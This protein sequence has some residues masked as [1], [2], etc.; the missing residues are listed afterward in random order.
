[1]YT[2]SFFNTKFPSICHSSS[3]NTFI[4]TFFISSTTL[5]TSLS[6]PL[7]IFIF[8]LYLPQVLLLLLLLNYESILLWLVFNFCCSFLL[9]LSS[10]VFSLVYLPFLSLF[11]I[12]ALRWNQ[13][14]TN[15]RSNR[16][17]FCSNFILSWSTLSFYNLSRPQ[18]WILCFLINAS[19][20]PIFLLLP[21]SL[22][23]ESHSFSLSYWEIL[24]FYLIG[25]EGLDT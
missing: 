7:A 4:P 17:V 10:L 21:I 19:N 9:L 13:I 5:I 11:L 6:F 23:N 18:T 22:Y 20:F 12:H 1:M 25:M 8:L 24:I 16:L 2:F 15:I 14:L 3:F